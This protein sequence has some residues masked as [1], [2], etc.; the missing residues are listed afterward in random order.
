MLKRRRRK[1]QNGKIEIGGVQ[2][3]QSLGEFP[4]EIEDGGHSLPHRF[5]R[6]AIVELPSNPHA[7]HNEIPRAALPTV[8]EQGKP[9]AEQERREDDAGTERNLAIALPIHRR[10]GAKIS[11]CSDARR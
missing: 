8:V 3:R 1:I 2:E 11:R 4:R 10:S 6:F 7:R 5:A 9:L